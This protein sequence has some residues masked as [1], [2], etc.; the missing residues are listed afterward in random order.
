MTCE[1]VAIN[2]SYLTEREFMIKHFIAMCL[3]F[4]LLDFI[5][6]FTISFKVN[7]KKVYFWLVLY[8]VLLVLYTVLERV[9]SLQCTLEYIII[10]PPPA[11][12]YFLTFL[13]PHT[14][15][16][17]KKVIPTTVLLIS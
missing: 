15:H 12:Y 11:D 4:H 17:L 6:N 9:L 13:Q 14:H 3:T 16:P 7:S 8:T 2:N 5:V 10:V 1:D